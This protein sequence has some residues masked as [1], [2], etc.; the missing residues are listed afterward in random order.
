MIFVNPYSPLTDIVIG[1]IFY[2]DETTPRPPIHPFT[3]PIHPFLKTHRV[4]GWVAKVD[5][6]FG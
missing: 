2:I 3:H 5:I 1:H 6:G 4:D